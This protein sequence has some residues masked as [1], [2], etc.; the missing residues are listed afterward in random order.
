MDAGNHTANRKKHS[1][2]SHYMMNAA[3]D[4]LSCMTAD[5]QSRKFT[6]RHKK[7]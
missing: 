1:A 3:D 6:L 5:G 7:V 2:Y 4:A